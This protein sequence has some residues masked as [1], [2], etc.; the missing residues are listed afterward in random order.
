[1]QISRN[2][3][4][5]FIM[6]VPD[7]Q[8]NGGRIES[9]D[10]DGGLGFGRHRIE[11][12]INPTQFTPRIVQYHEASRKGEPCFSWTSPYEMKRDHKLD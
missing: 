6:K 2:E 11:L 9:F 10:P 4:G 7:C 5:T 12:H 3:A 8:Q 1:M